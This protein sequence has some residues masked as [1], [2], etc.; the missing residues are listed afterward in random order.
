[1]VKDLQ[2]GENKMILLNE[3]DSSDSDEF[4]KA[5]DIFICRK[6]RHIGKEMWRHGDKMNGSEGEAASGRDM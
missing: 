3:D 1:M 4:H 6:Y 2:S 5:W